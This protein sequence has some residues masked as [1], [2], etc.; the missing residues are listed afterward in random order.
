MSVKIM[1]LDLSLVETVWC[2]IYD[3]GTMHKGTVTT[4]LKGVERLSAIK[5]M[6]IN[7][8]D[9]FDPVL[10]VI[11]GYSFGSR[12]RAIFSIG[13]L[14]GVVKTMLF[15]REVE[16]IDVAPTMVKKYATGKG[17]SPKDNVMLSVYKKWGVEFTNNNEC[18]AYVLA[19]IGFS[20]LDIDQ[21]LTKYQKEVVDKWL[22]D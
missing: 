18:D 12:G 14:G 6:L 9:E 10:V 19:H 16:F 5:T 8:I 13:E 17:T 1:G 4:K 22:K 3:D 20:T 7:I 2:V 15:D 11:E 21:N